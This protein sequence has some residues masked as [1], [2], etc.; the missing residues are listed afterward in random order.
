MPTFTPRQ[1][2]QPIASKVTKPDDN[3]WVRMKVAH[4]YALL[5]NDGFYRE[6]VNPTNEEI[7]AAD[8][9]YLGGHIYQVTSDEAAAL[10]A[11]GYATT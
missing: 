2:D 3:L 4:S 9:A 7:A 1:Y 5:K 11:A 6:V 10:N 8:I